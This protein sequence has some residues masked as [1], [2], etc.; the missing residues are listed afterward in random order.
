MTPRSQPGKER[1]QIQAAVNQMEIVGLGVNE[2]TAQV[3]SSSQSLLVSLQGPG[4]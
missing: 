3:R 4:V 1:P 2:S